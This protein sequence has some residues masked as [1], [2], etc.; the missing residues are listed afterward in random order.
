MPQAGNEKSKHSL[1]VRGFQAH[2]SAERT[3]T[4]KTGTGKKGCPGPFFLFLPIPAPVIPS[5]QHRLYTIP[6]PPQA[7]RVEGGGFH[8]VGSEFS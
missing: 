6:S 8:R 7:H 5:Q 4:A 2:D 3:R 1:Q